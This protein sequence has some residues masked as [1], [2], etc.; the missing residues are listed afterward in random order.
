M[1]SQSSV[2]IGQQIIIKLWQ[3]QAIWLYQLNLING[4]NNGLEDGM[5]YGM[6]YG[7]EQ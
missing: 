3:A 7:M 6:D 5:D 4:M 2:F 1:F